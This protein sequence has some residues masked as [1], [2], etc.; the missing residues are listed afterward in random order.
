M[1]ISYNWLSEYLPEK[2]EPEKLSKIL[3]AIGLEVESLEHYE[4]IKGGLK[5]LVIGEVVE[6]AQHA[7]ADK[8]KVTKVNTGNGQLLQIVCGAPNVAAGQKVVVATVGTTIYP[9]KGEPMTMKV[10]KIRG[11]ESHGMICAEDEIG[12]SEDHA[13]IMVLPDDAE[14]GTP[15][16]EY[17]K[18]YADWIYEIGLTPNRSDAMSHLGVAKDVCAYL[19]HHEQ[20]TVKPKLPFT[21]TFKPD[22]NN[23][24]ITVTIENKEACQRYSALSIAGITVKESPQWLQ[25]K[26]KAIGQK[27]INNIV[28]ITNFILH[29]TGQPLHAFDADEIKGGK[30]IVK[31]LPEGSIFTTL[32]GKERKLTANDL[33]ICNAEEGMCIAGV[34]GG[35][36]S[37]VKNS[38]KNIFLESAWFNPVNIRRTSIYHDLRTDAAA[39]FEKGVDISN[40]VNVLKRAALLIKEIAGGTIASDIED[41]Y[42]KREEKV[43]VGLKYSYLKKLSGKNYQPDAVKNILENLGFDIINESVN[44]LMVTVPYNKTDIKLP[45]DLVEEVVRI[46]GLDNI[47]IPKAITITPAT[48]KLALKENLKEKLSNY[49]TGIGLSEILTNSITNSNYYSEEETKYAVKMMNSLTVELNV[50]RPSMLETALESIAYNINRKNANLHFFEFGKT[51]SIEQTGVYKEEEH[52][53]LYL[54]GSDHYDE[55]RKKSQPSD[56]FVAKG[57]ASSLLKIC[58]LN[59][60]KFEEP[61]KEESGLDYTIKYNSVAIGKLVEVSPRRLK[62]FDIKQ[63]VY[64]I[65]LNYETVLGLAKKREIIFT[66]LGKFQPVFRDLAIIVDKWLPFSGL[67]STIK[68]LNLTKLQEIRLFDVFESDKL[69]AN[70]K[71]LALNFIFVDEN[72]T[73]TDKEI[74]GMMQQIITAI[75]KQLNGEIRK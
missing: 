53:S 51:Y 70:K 26:L 30:V 50:L 47:E 61:I 14:V 24:P 18:T 48:E 20:K 69:G 56:F 9:L 15:A 73:L 42:P 22:N 46:D 45:A 65:D 37:G 35:V 63:P 71:S 3:T 54:T 6:C 10:A 19:S 41:V 62:I 72:K 7:N 67:E 55:W 25:D 75:E 32:D 29:E 11:V 59:D 68:K 31:N 17:F 52:F 4:S 60:I 27:P 5:G 44:E 64:F 21:E 23:L 34:Y 66:E 1:T 39:R 43:K 28:D 58:G 12:F 13:G 33:M 49:L 36:K 57:I 38:T 74:D 2:I 40:T 16:S 8:L